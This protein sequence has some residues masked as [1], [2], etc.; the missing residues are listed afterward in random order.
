MARDPFAYARRNSTVLAAIFAG[1]V[2]LGLLS[3]NIAALIGGVGGLAWLFQA[4][5]KGRS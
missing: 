5:W 1:F 3:D 4:W 2:A